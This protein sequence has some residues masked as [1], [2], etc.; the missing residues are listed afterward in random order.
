MVPAAV[1]C[2]GG[3]RRR[4]VSQGARLARYAMATGVAAALVAVAVVV[5]ALRGGSRPE[6]MVARR[7]LHALFAADAET[8]YELT[9]SSYRSLVFPAEHAEMAAALHAVVGEQVQIRVLG[10]ERTSASDPAES[11]VGYRATT[12]A[13]PLRGVVTML[14]VDSGWWVADTSYDFR[15]PPAGATT[16]LDDVT[17][18]L[19]HQIAERARRIRSAGS[20]RAP[21]PGPSGEGVRAVPSPAVPDRQPGWASSPGQGGRSSRRTLSGLTPRS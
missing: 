10:S 7:Y 19:N 15:D 14:R 20:T 17:R 4:T 16:E 18:R 21:T 5:V 9:T 13:G 3:R 2:V 1:T 11:L 8:S 12:Q 6:E